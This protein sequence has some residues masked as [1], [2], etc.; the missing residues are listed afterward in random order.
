VYQELKVQEPQARPTDRLEGGFAQ[1]VGELW[2][3]REELVAKRVSLKE[4]SVLVEGGK[5]DPAMGEL[6]F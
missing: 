3:Q 5:P 2:Y 4:E 6:L 1:G